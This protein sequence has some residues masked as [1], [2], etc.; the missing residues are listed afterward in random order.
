M[1]TRSKRWQLIGFLVAK[2]VIVILFV[3]TNDAFFVYQNF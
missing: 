2:V 1:M 3:N